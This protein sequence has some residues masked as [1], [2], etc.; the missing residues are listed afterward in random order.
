MH[1][2]IRGAVQGVGFRPFVYRLARELHLSG[3]VSNSSQGVF[4]EAEGAPAALE[5]FLHRLRHEH[6]P[7]AFIQS[8]EYS[9]LDPEGS[10]DFVIRPSD[11][12]GEKS[13]LIMPDIALCEDCLR[14]LFDP[15][16]RR[17]RYPFIN[18]TNCGPR[19][20]IITGLPYD[21]P[22]TTMSTFVM[23]AECRREYEDPAD[24]RF[25]AQPNACPVCGPRITLWDTS[26][27]TRGTNDNALA[28]TVAALREGKIVAVKGIGGFHLMVAAAD[29]QAVLRLRARKHRE[30]KPF[31]LMFPGLASIRGIC[32]VSDHEAQVLAAPEAPIVLLRRL[33]G[34]HTAFIADAVAPHNPNLGAMLPYAPL[35]HLLMHDFGQPVVATSGNL[36][37]E[38]ICIDEDEALRRLAGIADL[39]LVHNRPIARHIDDSIVRVNDGRLTVLR[40][41]RGFAPLPLRVR[42]PLPEL[43]A[44]GAHM[45]STIALSRGQDIVLSQ[46][47]GDLETP[48]AYAAFQDEAARLQLLCEVHP[49]GVVSDSH[50]DYLS[51]TY[52]RSR[53]ERQVR[54]QHHIA[55]VAACMA[56]NEIAPPFLGV[57][58]DGT[59][60]GDDGTIW[61]GEFFA[62]RNGAFERVA[63]LRTFPLAGGDAAAREPRRS[64]AG[65]L[66]E[67][68]GIESA[69]WEDI[70]SLQA[71]TEN[72][73]AAVYQMLVRGFNTAITSSA[74][75]LFDAVSALLG[76]RQRNNFEGQ[77]A[78]ELEWC[79]EDSGTSIYPVMF[80]V[81]GT[82]PDAVG[83]H[84][85]DWEP[86]IREILADR[87]AGLMVGQIAAKFHRTLAA[88]IV[89]VAEEIGLERVALTGGCFQNVMLTRLSID[90][91]TAAGFHPY[92][93]Q[94][95]PPNDGGIALGQI[96]AAAY[97]KMF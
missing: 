23:C 30:E 42:Q 18:C 32:T 75:R 63:H 5:S 24:R 44:V 19:F 65:V 61:G 33:S 36:S 58:W 70:P 26:G 21:R 96:A 49:I 76:I 48:E 37:D 92:I 97:M 27:A 47:L 52:A 45:K 1:G 71:F 17:H 25:H 28:L 43:L 72:D 74:G 34:S 90:A 86:M 73:R 35:H 2:V 85:L 7:R 14:E 53:P 16:N 3:W 8:F 6:P 51:S 68:G 81:S 55:H 54:I 12:S 15:S 38:P 94:R 64:A 80:H 91:L 95:I 11:P 77:A 67:I 39:L 84:I 66:F 29:E 89:R 20:S 69:G 10:S 93:H 46:H 31:A 56:E 83:R 87:T 78:M 59:G 9:F 4:L 57:A 22:Y 40:R 62:V 82:G 88:M 13:A 50:P 41:A 79:T 60:L